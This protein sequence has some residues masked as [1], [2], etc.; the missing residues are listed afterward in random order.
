MCQN[1]DAHQK[2]WFIEIVSSDF[3]LHGVEFRVMYRLDGVNFAIALDKQY[4]FDKH[5]AVT[6]KVIIN[7]VENW[8][9][10]NLTKICQLKQKTVQHNSSVS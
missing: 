9:R 4:H 6:K 10:S 2:M 7:C 5:Q 8:I 3:H 1:A